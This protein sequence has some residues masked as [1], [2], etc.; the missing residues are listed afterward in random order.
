L[1]I[2]QGSEYRK[3]NTY[4]FY[5]ILIQPL[6]IQAFCILHFTSVFPDSYRGCS[7]FDIAFMTLSQEFYR[8]LFARLAPF[9][10]IV[11]SLSLGST[12]HQRQLAVRLAAI[13]SGGV[14]VDLMCGTGLSVELVLKAG[15]GR[16][17]GVDSS[18]EMMQQQVGDERVSFLEAN[19]TQGSPLPI[20]A[21][22]VVS[23]YGIKCL[24]ISEYTVFAQVI[25][26]VLKPG[27]TVSILEFRLPP[28]R[29]FRFFANLYVSVFCGLVCFLLKGRWPPT[30]DLYISMTPD[31]NPALMAQLLRDHGFSITVSER[32][33][34]SAVLIYGHKQ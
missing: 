24:D 3:E 25:D 28:S 16:Y 26:Q 14:V 20:L 13:R 32:P 12:R 22:H 15:A 1:N 21:D 4:E 23:S 5:S 29:I 33:L 11:D 34:G 30:R 27:G 7:L 9:Y 19:L 2:E 31:I 8:S 6:F 10:D 17:I 18:V